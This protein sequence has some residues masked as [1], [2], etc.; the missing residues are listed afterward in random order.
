MFADSAPTPEE[1]AARLSQEAFFR[2]LIRS[3]LEVLTPREREIVERRHLRDPGDT[4]EEIGRDLGV[5]RERVR[6]LEGASMTKLRRHVSR[7]AGRGC[8]FN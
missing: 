1:N 6:Q 7:I 3:S 5:T 4:L 8:L 2:K